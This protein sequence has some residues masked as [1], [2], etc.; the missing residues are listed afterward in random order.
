MI[1]IREIKENEPD[2]LREMLYEAIYIPPGK[3]KP[4]KSIVFDPQLSKYVENFGRRGDFAFVLVGENGLVG[5]I[6]TRLFDKKAETYGFVDEETPELSIAI[7]E[8]Y[9]NRGF[10]GLLLENLFQKLKANGFNKVSLSVDK[11]NPA[12]NLY[13][14]FGFEIV[15]EQGTAFT[16]LKKIK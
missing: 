14:R 10:G 8:D 12:V 1:K 3:P 15:S 16:M 11:Q 7:R 5:A 2:F 6:W 4:P 13:Q 9:R